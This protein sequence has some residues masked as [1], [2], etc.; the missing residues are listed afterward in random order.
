MRLAT[1]LDDEGSAPRLGG[2]TT[3]TAAIGRAPEGVPILDDGLLI[4]LRGALAR[5]EMA[6]RGLAADD[7]LEFAVGAERVSG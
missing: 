4:A 3:I 7:A 2:A 6:W 5:L 1:V